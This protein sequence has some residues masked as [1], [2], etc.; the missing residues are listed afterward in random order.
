MTNHYQP[1]SAMDHLL[2]TTATTVMQPFSNPS[3]TILQPSMGQ[4]EAGCSLT[5]RW[6]TQS[7][8]FRANLGD[9]STVNKLS[10]GNLFTMGDG[11]E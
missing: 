2:S 5:C 9:R 11:G 4:P 10:K 7:G 6:L 3:P 1:L 8:N